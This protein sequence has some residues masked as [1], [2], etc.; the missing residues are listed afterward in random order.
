ML[1]VYSLNYKR[2]QAPMY[3]VPIGKC[4]L[5]TKGNDTRRAYPAKSAR[6]NKIASFAPT[7]TDVLL[8]ALI[9]GV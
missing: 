1:I 4:D 5:L 2:W 8:C 9:W 7:G 3:I 6:D